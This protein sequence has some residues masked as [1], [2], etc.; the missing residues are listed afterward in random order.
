MKNKENQGKPYGM[1]VELSDELLDVVAGGLTEEERQM[2][3][4][5]INPA[6]QKYI[7]SE[8]DKK[9]GFHDTER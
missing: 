5:R 1:G 8:W 6:S 7:Q 4:E 9:H 3:M 2:I